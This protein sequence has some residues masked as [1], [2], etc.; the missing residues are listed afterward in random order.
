MPDIPKF[1]AFDVTSN[2]QRQ[3]TFNRN[4]GT[5]DPLAGTGASIPSVL[6]VQQV[7]QNPDGSWNQQL[8]SQ[9]SPIQDQGAIENQIAQDQ[10]NAIISYEEL[11]AVY[12]AE[13]LRINNEISDKKDQIM[14]LVTAAIGAGCSSKIPTGPVAAGSSI[15]FV[16]GADNIGGVAV[17]VGSTVVNDKV[18]IKIYSSLSNYSAD[19]PYD[20]RTTE[21]LSTSNLG[22]GYENVVNNNGGSVVS[23]TYRFISS[24]SADHSPP[25]FLTFPA[26]SAAE[27]AACAGYGA[28][29]ISIANE[30]ESLRG[31]RDADLDRINDLKDLKTREEIQRWGI[32]QAD[33]GLNSYNALLQNAIELIADYTDNIVTENLIVHYDAGQTYGIQA[34]VESVTNINAISQWNNLVGDGLYASPRTS[35]YSINL[36]TGDGPSVELNNYPTQT[37]QYFTVSS[38]FIESQKIGTGSTAYTIESW[39]KVTNDVAL[40]ISST[41]NGANL[42]GVSSEFGYGLQVYK[43]SGIRLSFGER[44]NGS[45]TNT[46]NLTTNTWYHVVATNDP[47]NGSRIYLNG[48][49]DGTG[50]QINVTTAVSDLQVGFSTHH[51]NQY[52]SGKISIIRIYNSSL[53][54]DQVTQNYNAHK[55]R[56]GY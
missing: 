49:L 40:G 21:Q 44:S 5:G 8:T 43:P 9:V 46:T 32:N 55:T 16:P 36:D 42:V 35:L 26:L 6:S 20:P 29:I 13:M 34:S 39:F 15:T 25:L 54:Q 28:S 31:D 22:K 10:N 12:D 1:P 19:S 38:S 18:S 17:G 2:L 27:I 33:S 41:T 3:L 51:I 30:I 11:G 56:F 52:F 50:S 24:E 14:N 48:I 37:N 47:T 4:A 7:S 45:L 53:T 23:S